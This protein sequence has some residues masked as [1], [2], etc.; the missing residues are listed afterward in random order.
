MNDRSIIIKVRK[1]LDKATATSN[2]YEAEAFSRKAAELLARYRIDP[3]RLKG[4]EQTDALDIREFE[5]G[6]GAYVRARLALLMAVAGPHD[7]KVVF[8]SSP[9]GMVAHAAGFE[10]DLDVVELIYASLHQQAATQMADIR[11][12]T[13]A[14][15]QRFRRSFLFGFADQIGRM[16]DEAQLN[17]AGQ[18]AGSPLAESTE[19]ALRNRV[20]QVE[21]HLL[22]AFGRVRAA[23]PPST[24]QPGGWKAGASAADRAD[25]GRT[26]LSGRPAIGPP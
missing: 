11:R 26:R 6:R 15:T 24:A 1:L 4:L 9:T 17:L 20:D 18:D 10:S 8:A 21:E 14:A 22:G 25:V 23:R 7:V 5:L 3:D 13:P 12:S 19:L 16:L 2:H